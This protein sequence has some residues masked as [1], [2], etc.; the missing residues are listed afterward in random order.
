V[1]LSFPQ[2]S[3]LAVVQGL[4]EFLP[5]SSSA[6]LI[7]ASEVMGWPDQGLAF[8]VAV[9]VSTLLAVVIYFRRDILR[10]LLAWIASLF[11]RRLDQDSKLA[12]LLIIASI[13][14]GIAGLL[15]QGFIEANFRSATVIAAANLFFA[16]LLWLS[17][18]LGS[19]SNPLSQLS[20]QQALCIGVGQCFALIPGT[21]RSGITMTVALL[22]GLN[23]EAAAKFSFLLAIPIILASGG[24]QALSL[25]EGSVGDI[26]VLQLFA[27]VALAAVVAVLCI[28]FFL[29]LIERIGFLPF[30]I[31]RLILGLGLV[32]LTVS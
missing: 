16:G 11:S 9:H 29:R 13:P 4:T 28:H 15:G 31:Y 24:L 23:R 19:R 25:R 14:A 17:D 2:A 32:L 7:L 22:C 21:S 18:R 12:W 5:I 8:D 27:A 3:L 20:W 10:L 6:H 30:I 1:D 26:D